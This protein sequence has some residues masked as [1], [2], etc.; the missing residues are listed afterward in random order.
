MRN[1]NRKRTNKIKYLLILL[2]G[3]TLGYALITTNLKIIGL[4]NI[5]TSRID[6]HWENVQVTEGSVEAAEPQIGDNKTSV[7]YGFNLQFPGDFY[8]FTVD[9]V[10]NSKSD[11]MLNVLST[12]F[13]GADGVTEVTLPPYIRY[14]LTYV[15][16]TPVQQKQLLKAKSTLR[17]RVRVEYER[18]SEESPDS[19]FE[20][21]AEV[22]TEYTKDDGTGTEVEDVEITIP[23]DNENFIRTGD[24]VVIA[25]PSGFILQDYKTISQENG[26]ITLFANNNISLYGTYPDSQQFLQYNKKAYER[27]Y[28]TIFTGLNDEDERASFSEYNYWEGKVGIGPGYTYQG[29]YTEG[30][31]PYVYEEPG[32][33]VSNYNYGFDA[34]PTEECII[35]EESPRSNAYCIYKHSKTGMP[36]CYRYSKVDSCINYEE[37]YYS[38]TYSSVTDCLDTYIPDSESYC[39]GGYYSNRYS[40]NISAVQ[41][42][43]EAHKGKLISL[44]V[45]VLSARLLSYQEAINLGYKNFTE[46]QDY[47]RD[48]SSYFWLGSASSDYAI[49]EIEDD[50]RITSCH[51]LNY[52]NNDAIFYAHGERAVR[53]VI[54][55]NARDVIKNGWIL[56]TAKNPKESQQW[57][58]RKNGN[59]IQSGWHELKDFYGHKQTYYFENGKAKIGWLEL[60]GKKYYLDPEDG[61]ENGYINCN[62]L[63]NTTRKIG[64]KRYK[65]NSNGECT[66]C[67]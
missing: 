50:D 15:N 4:G 21:S 23:K 17:Y 65:F 41:S 55:L 43:L 6:A 58:Y 27:K 8:E 54:I 63:K 57:E 35:D 48:D 66:N 20:V 1:R 9:A 12:K 59:V 24:K 36:I 25:N 22:D 28:N 30:N 39:R 51:Y 56:L 44:G 16:G 45:P 11:A 61:D 31:Y 37:N 64:N 47:C 49:F 32:I 14:S 53:P 42:A 38:G 26:L 34:P 13:Y 10:N 40:E 62:L 3:L 60:D 33:D 18:G 46:E 67:D 5:N 7:T 52:E 2:L 29:S 19:N